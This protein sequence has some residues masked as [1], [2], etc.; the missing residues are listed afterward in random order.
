MFKTISYNME[1]KETNHRDLTIEEFKEVLEKIVIQGKPETEL[2]FP[3]EV[4]TAYKKAYKETYG[5][6]WI[7][8]NKDY[9]EEAKIILELLNMLKSNK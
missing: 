2:S 1:N 9:T 8:P 4:F 3:I 6:E 7:E 5:V